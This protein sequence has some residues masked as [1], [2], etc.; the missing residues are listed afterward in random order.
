MTSSAQDAI[1]EAARDVIRAEAAGVAAAVDALD[2]TFLDVARLLFD[3]TG[4]VFVIGS[5][6]SG[7]VARR[8]AH[9][10]AVAGTPSVFMHPADALHG[11]MGAVT[12]GDIVIAISRG[13]GS[14]EVNDCAERTRARGAVIV[15]LTAKGESALAR[16]AD[17]AVVLPM[18]PGIDPG[19][20]IAMGST[21]V[22]SVWGDAMAVVLMRLRG[23]SWSDV[24]FTHPSGAVG[25]VSD[26]PPA[27]PLLTFDLPADAVDAAKE[28]T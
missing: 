3:C 9:L 8:M 11:T 7:A 4:K 16:S 26:E 1:L 25:L 27:L 21:L 2:Q 5:G 20:V 14:A 15:A 28:P 23:Y 6:T 19:D 24:L 17:H 18:H 12:P 13:G 22:T 10:L